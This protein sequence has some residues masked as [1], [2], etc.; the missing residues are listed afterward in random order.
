MSSAAPIGLLGGTFDPIHNGHLQLAQDAIDLLR[1]ASVL[2]I[3]AGQPPHRSAPRASARDRLEM[4]RRAVAGRSSLAI[5]DGEA[6]S[7]QPSYTVLTLQRLRVAGGP[8]QPLVLLLGADAFLG[9]ASWHRWHDLFGL[10]HIGV[11]TRPGHVLAPDAM[12]DPLRHEYQARVCEDPPQLRAAPAGLVVP[13]AMTPMEISATAIRAA[14]YRG[15][16][17]TDLLPAAVLDY[18]DRHTLYRS[19]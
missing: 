14:L 8:G 9:L 17:P 16:R 11:A 7:E 1:L 2:V 5:D 10:A 13:F 3:P 4:A 15:E 6:L 19:P 12:P 18:I